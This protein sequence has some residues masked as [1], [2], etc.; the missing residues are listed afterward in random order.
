MAK[1]GA[2]RNRFAELFAA[3]AFV[4]FV[5]QPYSAFAQ[6]QPNADQRY[7]DTFEAMM[8]EPADAERSFNF[9]QA[10]SAAGDFRG[11]IAALERILQ[12][13][14]SL[15]NI[16]LELGVL[17]LRVGASDLAASY[18]RRALLAPDVP[19]A[20]R[21]RAQSILARA[22]RSRQKHFV[23]GSVYAG[24]RYDSNA[25]AGPESRA[26]RVL[27]IDGLLDE[28]STG[29]NDF[30][31]ELVGALSY[32]YAL[33]S[34]AGHEIEANFLTYNRRYDESSEININSLGFDVGPR[35]Y[36][37]PLLEPT[38]S[39]RPFVSASYIFLDDE[40]YLR[41]A[42]GGVNVRQFFGPASFV[43]GAIEASD[44]KFFNSEERAAT[45]L[46]SGPFV[47]GRSNFAWQFLPATRLFGGL[48]IGRRDSEADFEAFNEGAARIG[49]TQ[50]Y[51]PPF[52]LTA[53]SWSTSLS[54]GIRRT[55]YDEADPL[56]D[57]TTK[58]QDSRAD[59]IL[60]NNIRMTRELTLVVSLQYTDND[61]S[62]P[63]F[64]YD[65][66]GASVGIA[67][68]F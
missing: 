1:R 10:A 63:N 25:N 12:V 55:V 30:S 9:A 31:G 23:T 58:R 50:V 28:G 42:G 33:D 66:K 37:G 49:V 60:S 40:G 67:Y 5:A 41:Q 27:G 8:A 47:E 26:V 35:F 59:V 15:A 29:R 16:Q 44:Q 45:S 22:E 39:V 61:S 34:Q 18:L 32:T 36:F 68:S 56:I 2:S 52:G 14:P 17:Y 54:A 57:P 48:S 7:Q 51:P 6:Q 43:E 65:N 20:V 38:L 62:L 4:I 46:R 13:N 19:D 53:Y 64:E 21:D 3:L 11:A 24:A